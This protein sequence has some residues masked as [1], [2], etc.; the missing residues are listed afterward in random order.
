MA[1]SKGPSVRERRV[2]RRLRK[3]R[4]DVAGIPTL[5][6]VASQLR[7]SPSKL[8]RLENAEQI[9]GPAEII[10]LATILGVDEEERDRVVAM[11]SRESAGWWL[12]YTPEIVPN[13]LA[14][15]L[16]TE[17]EAS[18]VRNV[19]TMLVPGLLQT[20]AY[21]ET[22]IRAWPAPSEHAIAE[23]L[24]VRQQ[25]QA[26][27]DEDP[28]L[29]LHAIVHENALHLP[30]GGREVML[31]QLDWL[32]SRAKQSK[33]TL[34]VLPIKI[35]AYG[36]MGASYHIVSFDG[37]EAAAVYL[38][39]LTDGQF[40]EEDDQVETFHRN[41]QRLINVALDPDASGERI[42]EIRKGFT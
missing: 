34:Q 2:A 6:P 29:P 23:R 13:A 21:A 39:R 37:D 11:A 32:L 16:E 38:D 22:L 4:T 40:V 36:G 19:E 10:A 9:A 14:D 33:I 41:F 25:R 17:A 42:L 7:W 31:E 8:S 1:K 3:W 26:R 28:P 30:I 35:G 24:S 18:I 27:L 15:Y 12:G 20:S 5:E